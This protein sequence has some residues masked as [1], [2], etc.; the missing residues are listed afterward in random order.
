MRKLTTFSIVSL[1]FI[2]SGCGGS[3]PTFDGS[4]EEAAKA[5]IEAMF[6]EMNADSKREAAIMEEDLPPA[7]E[8]YMCALMKKAFENFGNTDPEA[9]EKMQREVSS[10]FDGMTAA[11]MEAY[12]IENDLIGCLEGFKNFGKDLEESFGK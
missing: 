9:E 5:S 8:V 7:L 10:I 11:D 4:S 1:I 2:L 3:E 12:G 6:P